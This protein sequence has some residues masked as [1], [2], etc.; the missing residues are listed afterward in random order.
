M[1][2]SNIMATN[3]GSGET[4]LNECKSWIRSLSGRTKGFCG[5]AMLAAII[6]NA[7]GC[8]SDEAQPGPE[9]VPIQSSSPRGKGVSKEMPMPSPHHWIQNDELYAVMKR[10]G[11]STSANWPETLPDD[12]EIE[13]TPQMRE[14]A[15]RDGVRLASAL[16]DSAKEIPRSV[17]GFQM[18]GADRMMFASNA[19]VLSDQARHLGRAARARNVESMQRQLDGIRSSC[20][21][22]HTRFKDISGDLPP[23]T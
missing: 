2:V 1:N 17:A 4:I 12:P 9:P 7:S 22:C 5:L 6:P 10:L 8:R 11:A 13:V 16:A 18:S 23:R 15:F 19:N 21:S 14:Q 20:V 3:Q